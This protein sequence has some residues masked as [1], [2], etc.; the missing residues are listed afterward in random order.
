[1]CRLRH[2]T[3]HSAHAGGLPLQAAQTFCK[4]VGKMRSAQT[5]REGNGL[6]RQHQLE[7]TLK[8]MGGMACNGSVWLSSP[9]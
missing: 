1:M 6:H 3:A 9:Q 4:E 5:M 8:W 7:N 2:S